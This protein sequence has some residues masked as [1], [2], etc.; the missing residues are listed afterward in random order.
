MLSG[1]FIL[2]NDEKIFAQVQPATGSD[3][4]TK[5]PFQ[6]PRICSL[7]ISWDR[8]AVWE[9]NS[10][11]YFFNEFIQLLFRLVGSFSIHSWIA[12]HPCAWW[13]TI[14]LH[15]LLTSHWDFSVRWDHELCLLCP[16]WIWRDLVYLNIPDVAAVPHCHPH[17]GTFYSLEI[18][19]TAWKSRHR[20]GL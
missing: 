8:C 19:N 18:E 9:F 11:K 12:S 4:F 7:G 17:H 13:W 3:T 1:C 6:P 14:F 16:V 20:A 10:P 15:L 5:I 2:R